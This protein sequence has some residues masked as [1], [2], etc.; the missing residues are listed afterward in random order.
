ML[1]TVR[2]SLAAALCGLLVLVGLPALGSDDAASLDGV[3]LSTES[4][5]PLADARVHVSDPVG[6]GFHTSEWTD[7]QGQFAIEGIDPATYQ[8]GIERDGVLYAVDSP[9]TLAAGS[10]QSV[11]LGVTLAPAETIAEQHN[12]SMNAFNNPLV[13]ALIVIA[14]G[15]VIG[16]IVNE[17]EKNNRP[18]SDSPSGL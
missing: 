10:D 16:L 8:I 3:I 5:T 1:D 15:L 9:L 11:H 13:I 12:K 18:D 6:G 2:R 17:V 14:G 7:A 4:G